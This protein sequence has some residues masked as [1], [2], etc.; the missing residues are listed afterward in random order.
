[1]AS[2]RDRQRKLERAR[3][4]RRLARQAH[5]ARRKRQIQAGVGASVALV[6]IVLGTTWLLGGFKPTPKP[7]VASGTC[8][9]TLKDPSTDP[10]VIDVGH[11][12]TTGERRTGHD[13]LTIKTNMGDIQ[14]DMDLAKNPC[15]AVSFQ[16]LG[17]K[18]YFNGSKCHRLSTDLKVLQC[19]DQKSDGT[20]SPS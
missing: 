10:S 3:A 8:T 19:G 2:K 6:V 20:A 9:W 15:T 16:Y 11:P 4:E 1:V 17:S 5:N 13:T 7:T 18:D 12:P 14:A